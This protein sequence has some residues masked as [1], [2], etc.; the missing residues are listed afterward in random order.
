MN[1]KNERFYL[2]DETENTKTR[3]ISFLGEDQRYDLAI[4][5]TER[6]YGKTL[7]LN[8]QNSLF[9]IIGHDDLQEDGYLEAA[10]QL[11]EA[12]AAELKDFLEEAI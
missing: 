11:S 6:Y 4:I 9:A 7:V 10:F 8:L 5:Q 3:F 12:E 1:E 2:Y